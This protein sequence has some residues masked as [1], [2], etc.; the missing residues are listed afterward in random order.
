[1]KLMSVVRPRT[2]SLRLASLQ[3]GG[4]LV[5]RSR[6]AS[7]M[8]SIQPKVTVLMGGPD[9]EHDVS[10]ASGRSVAAALVEAGFDQVIEH[11]IERK[12][13]ERIDDIPGDVLFPVLHGPW[14]KAAHS[15]CSSR[16]MVDHSSDASAR[17][18]R[19]NG[20]ASNQVDR[21]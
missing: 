16:R 18:R 9:G 11:V 5:G 10:L 6:G 19:G 20:Q 1:M 15:N 13:L 2:R 4:D 17:G 12:P 14:G 8:N 3:R 7:A 21:P